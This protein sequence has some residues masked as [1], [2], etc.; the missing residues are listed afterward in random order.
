MTHTLTPVTCVS[1][2]GKQAVSMHTNVHIYIYQRERE[3]HTLK[4]VQYPSVRE[5]HTHWYGEERHT[6]TLRGTSS[7][8]IYI[9][10][11]DT[12]IYERE[13]HIY[14]RERHTYI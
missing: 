1:H 7:I 12:Y 9:W 5:R 8:Y 14:M 3:T 11:R 2:T 10:E 6:G 4:C 13:T